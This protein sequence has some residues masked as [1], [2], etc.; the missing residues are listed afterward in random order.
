MSSCGS[1][2]HTKK[3][4][5]VKNRGPRLGAPPQMAQRAS[6]ARRAS[7][8][9]KRTLRNGLDERF[10]GMV[11]RRRGR[12]RRCRLFGYSHQ[13]GCEGCVTRLYDHGRA[14]LGN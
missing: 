2:I 10:M 13:T 6:T 4:D 9:L 8:F 14:T 5:P 3:N 1:P 12:G 11:A 7:H